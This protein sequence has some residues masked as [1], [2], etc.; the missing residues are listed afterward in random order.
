[1]SIFGPECQKVQK[2]KDDIKEMELKRKV[3]KALLV[4][5]IDNLEALASAQRATIGSVQRGR[6]LSPNYYRDLY[7]IPPHLRFVW[8]NRELKF[9]FDTNITDVILTIYRFKGKSRTFYTKTSN[10]EA[11]QLYSLTSTGISSDNFMFDSTLCIKGSLNFGLSWVKFNLVGNE[12][13]A[14]YEIISHTLGSA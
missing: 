1:M 10:Y 12:T 9:L 13:Y 8:V 2:I 6:L 11:D 5:K 14:H 4:S 7:R 3:N